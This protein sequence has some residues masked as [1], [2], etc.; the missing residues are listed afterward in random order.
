[1]KEYSLKFIQL[2]R[3]APAMGDDSRARMS[4]FVANVSEDVVKKNVER[5]C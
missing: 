2:A 3:Y 4:K 5:L 1:M